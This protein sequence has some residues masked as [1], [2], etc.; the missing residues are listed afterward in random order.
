MNDIL[1]RRK[2]QLEECIADNLRSMEAK[3]MELDRTTGQQ[4]RTK[5]HRQRLEAQIE[6][7]ER[8]NERFYLQLDELNEKYNHEQDTRE[9]DT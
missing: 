7:L 4:I 5:A 9:T 3:Q 8:N 1:Q 2:E 6:C